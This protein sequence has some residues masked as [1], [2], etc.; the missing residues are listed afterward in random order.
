V[1]LRRRLTDYLLGLLEQGTSPE[2]LA[3]SLAV[4]ACLGLFPILGV[5]TFLCL[6]VGGVFRLNHAALQ[7][8]NYLVM[9]LQLV[10]ILA[11]VRLGEWLTGAATMPVNPLELASLARAD[12][13]GFLARFGL[14]VLRGILGWSVVTPFVGPSLH[15]MLLPLVRGMARGLRRLR[16]VNENVL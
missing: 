16:P 9:P 8:A 1:T 13:S 10:L 12:P 7:I 2:S 6:L 4:G 14:T 3:L 5:T 15:A 11:F